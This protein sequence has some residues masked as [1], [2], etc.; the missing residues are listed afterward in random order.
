MKTALSLIAGATFAL[1]CVSTNAQSAPRL[2]HIKAEPVTV[3]KV[4]HIGIYVGP[5]PVYHPHY[6]PHHVPKYA[7]HYRL[8]KRPLYQ[9]GINRN[10]F[11]G[12]AVT[13]AAVIGGIVAEH[14]NMYPAKHV[15]WCKRKYRSYQVHSDTFQP[16]KGPRKHCRS[17]YSPYR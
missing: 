13:G 2:P 12:G 5:A 4:G 6:H 7:P 10:A 16:F 9:H 14:I 15:S 8:P 1:L 3:Q 17:P 11:L